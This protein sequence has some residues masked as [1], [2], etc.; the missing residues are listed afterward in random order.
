MDEGLALLQVAL[1]GEAFQRLGDVLEEGPPVAVESHVLHQVAV[2]ALLHREVVIAVGVGE[3]AV[4]LLAH[5]L[6]GDAEANSSQTVAGRSCRG[7]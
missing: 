5:R 3:I 7:R 1:R 2:N 6:V 4:N